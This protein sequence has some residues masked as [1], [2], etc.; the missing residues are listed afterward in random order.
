MS[1][2]I[3][4]TIYAKEHNISRQAV[5]AK[6][7]KGA[8]PS[9]RVDGKIYI[10]LEEEMP[11]PP[12]SH[13]DE[14]QNRTLPTEEMHALLASK[15]ETI[16]VLKE[17]IQDLKATNTEINTTLR[18]EI[19]LLKQ[20]F[21]EMRNLYVKQV[22]YQTQQHPLQFQPAPPQQKEV[23]N[24]S[25]IKEEDRECWMD[26]ESFLERAGIHKKKKRAKVT[27]RLRHAYQNDDPRIQMRGGDLFMSCYDFYE[28]IL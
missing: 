23:L 10:I 7:K 27:K 6:I 26:L 8:L 2:L 11:T 13:L 24:H 19:E 5:Y 12:N 21:A 4:P 22:N 25:L 14:T 17:S 1:R 18:G 16:A 15:E 9:K 20:V 28:D 3:K